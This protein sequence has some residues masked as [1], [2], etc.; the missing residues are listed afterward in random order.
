MLKSPFP[1]W[2]MI[3]LIVLVIPVT[4]CSRSAKAQ[5]A[6][7]R[8]DRFFGE[9]E[10][11]KAKIE[12]MNV[13]R[14]KG[15]DAEVYMRLGQIW[16][17]QGAPLSAG[18]FLAQ[19]HQLQPEHVQN[20]T[21]LAQTLM[22]LGQ[23]KQ[24]GET[25]A[26][27]LQREPANKEAL[28]L[29]AQAAQTP[30][31]I[32]TAEQLL[33][34]FPDKSSPHFHLATAALLNQKGD[35][36]AA[37]Q[38]VDRALAADPKSAD[39]H[40]IKASFHQ[41]RGEVAEAERMLKTAAEI[42]APRSGHHLAYAQLLFNSGRQE[43]AVAFLKEEAK[44]TPDYLPTWNL[45]ARFALINK[46]W[47]EVETNVA[48]VIRIDPDN[49][50]ARML[51]AELW[52][53]RGET[54]K[55]REHLERLD[56]AY[57]NVPEIKMAL[58]RAQAQNQKISQ[59]VS[60]LEQSLAA[61]PNRAD[62]V[63]ALAELNIRSGKPQ[64]AIK[65]LEDLLAARPELLN[66][67]RLLTAAYQGAGR[68]DD[69]IAILRQQIIALPD[70]A[71]PYYSLGLI[72]RTRGQNA[73][74]RDAFEKSAAI[75]P[76]NPGP[77]EQLVE[78]DLTEKQFDAAIERVQSRLLASDPNSAPAHFL[79]GKIFGAAGKWDQA[80]AALEKAIQL[81]AN[82]E[83]AYRLL[84][85]TY[86][87]SGRLS[88]AAAR[89]ET[90]ATENL[91]SV[92]LWATLGQVYSSLK[93]Y[94]K[95]R[96]AYE[97]ALALEPNAVLVL[98]NLAFLQAERLG[99]LEK[100][101][102]LASRAR[103]LAPGDPNVA[104]TLG[105]IL[106]KR[107]DHQQASTLLQEAAAK[108]PEN[109]TLQF[110]YGMAS[111][112]LGNTEAARSALEKA[113]NSPH[114]FAD[115]EAA[116][117]RLAMLAS[118]GGAA[119]AAA[120]EGALQTKPDDPVA[121]TRLAA[122]HEKEGDFAKAAQALQQAL[123]ASPRL[124]PALRRL[125]ELNLGPLNNSAQ[126]LEFA[127][128]AREADPHNPEILALFGRAS[129]AAGNFQQAYSVLQTAV[130]QKRDDPTI[131]HAFAWAAYSVGR[132][133]EALEAMKGAASSPDAPIAADA[134]RFVQLAGAARSENVDAAT[135]TA[136]TEAVATDPQ[137]VPAIM[138]QALAAQAK[139]DPAAA[140][141]FSRVLARFPD[142]APAEKHLA[143]IYAEDPA[144][145]AK[146]YELAVKARK[147]LSDDADL[148]RT[149]AR[150]H[151]ARKEYARA[152]QL[153]EETRGRKPLGARDLYTLGASQLRLDDK[154]G[155]RENLQRALQAGL[156]APL[157]EEARRLLT[158]AGA[159]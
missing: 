36:A 62:A 123:K 147:T 32:A 21:R 29:V 49:F 159:E 114:D 98:N 63:L 104:D 88:D 80:I 140:A 105:W 7:E 15:P 25:A 118:G 142:F 91:K 47:K 65:P 102:E 78:I 153:L 116:R 27:L 97:K 156:S 51:Q 59:A 12:Y 109:P 158:E 22:L 58:A 124:L 121:W 95:A 84:V 101:Q 17:E 26:R 81:D 34:P 111:Y 79:L 28:L 100:A 154:S 155:A 119:D 4:G 42:G 145:Q 136:A 94:E 134:Q 150:L 89:L 131:A 74:A 67:Q 19:A 76:R 43:E 10:H 85:A 103:N 8:A 132:E 64:A 6:L 151:Y 148:V 117:Q 143:A 157:A 71:E 40:A 112:M 72:L 39:A 46:S 137:Y 135:V 75:E 16:F 126:A 38:H 33:E 11:E 31:E 127:K 54:T 41:S 113:V 86:I 18:P 90:L 139:G 120:L 24:A 73:E 83:V 115:R 141:L 13:L 99:D 146:A 45:L 69:A 44:K 107:G 3:A 125:V 37:E 108:L 129:Y 152:V 77:I 50:D 68:L 87:S 52:L 48:N 20:S 110:H 9:G 130:R 128:R 53:V 2:L 23:R 57:P 93:Q 14:A 82:L 96:D 138:V 66:A 5:R 133:N 1:H 149:L 61:A 106:F 30:D 70:W 60:T 55:A 56:A 92:G 35:S 144:Q 122:Q